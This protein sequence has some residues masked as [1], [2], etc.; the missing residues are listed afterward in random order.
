MLYYNRNNS[1]ERLVIEGPIL[2]HK[3]LP[4]NIV[5]IKLGLVK[6]TL[7]VTLITSLKELNN[8]LSKELF[9]L[10]VLFISTALINLNNLKDNNKEI[11]Y[12]VVIVVLVIAIIISASCCSVRQLV[13]QVHKLILY[14]RSILLNKYYLVIYLYFQK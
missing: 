12:L 5:G 3:Q 1:I 9:I 14:L 8:K 4:I 6:T 7:R 13:V 10:R 11:Y 2:L